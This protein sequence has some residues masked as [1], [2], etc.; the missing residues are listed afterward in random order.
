MYQARGRV[1]MCS[2][3]MVEMCSDGN[4]WSVDIFLKY[5]SDHLNN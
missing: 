5:L 1:G 4:A 2:G 3:A